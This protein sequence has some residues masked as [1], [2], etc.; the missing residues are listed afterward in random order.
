MSRLIDTQALIG[1]I[2]DQM[3]RF[4]QDRRNARMI[5]EMVVRQ[6]GSRLH[7]PSPTPSPTDHAR[8]PVDSSLSRSL[9]RNEHSE[10]E[11]WALLSAAELIARVDELSIADLDVLHEAEARGRN[12]AAV[13]E[14]IER[15]RGHVD[16]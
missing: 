8:S 11:R 2:T 9:A 15:R 14:A 6:F 10:V 3:R 16:A 13:L 4:D 12:R 7:R 1:R 5:G